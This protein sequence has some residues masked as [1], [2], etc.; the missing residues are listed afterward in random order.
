MVQEWSDDY[1]IGIETIDA[2]HRTFFD[3][4]RR[5]Y[6]DVLMSKGEEAIQESLM[7]L[8]NYAAEH[9]KD[10]DAF[11]KEHEYPR[12]ANHRKLHAEFVARLDELSAQF[13][14]EM[15]PTQELADEILEMTQEWLIE[16]ITN[17]DVLRIRTL[18]HPGCLGGKGSH[19]TVE[20]GFI[21]VVENDGM[22]M[23]R[24]GSFESE[25]VEL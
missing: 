20:D 13:D 11:M 16:H 14:R 17:E 5:L 3:A 22:A 15:T 1:L 2:Q 19:Q 8:R 25:I 18:N 9:F 21:D 10:E 12:L 23:I 24:R 6:D 4:T 7:F